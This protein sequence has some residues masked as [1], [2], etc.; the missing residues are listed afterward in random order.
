MRTL[1]FAIIIGFFV[2]CSGPDKT[3]T[4]SP[5]D[6]FIDSLLSEMTIE[7]KIG[8]MS[9]STGSWETTG[10]IIADSSTLDLVRT[11]RLGSFLNVFGAERTRKAQEIAVNGS[12]LGIPLIFGYDM[13]HGYA[14]T[15]PIPLA[16][17][18]SWDLELIK[19]SAAITALEASAAGLHWN[20][21]PMVD[22]ARDPRWGRIMEGAGEDPWWGSQVAIARVRGY[23]GNDL[24]S[25]STIAAT[26]KHFAGYGAA[27][28]GRDY[29]T[30][31]ISEH[32]LRDV[33]LVPFQ[34]AAKAGVAAFM[35]GFN[36][37]NGT[38][39]TANKF[40]VRQILKKEWDW[41]GLVVSDWAS[42]QELTDHG[43]AATDSEAAG[44]AL[45]AGCDMEMVSKT[46]DE[47]LID[48]VQQHPEYLPMID[49][50]TLRI[51]GVK[52]DLGLFEDPFRY[53]DLQREKQ[54]VRNNDHFKHAREIAKRSIVL[55]ENRNRTLPLD[56][57]LRKIAVIGPLAEDRE[58]ALGTW[59]AQGQQSDVTPLLQGIQLAVG[60]K[61]KVLYAA[62]SEI[63]STDKS[64]FNKARAL[65][66]QSDAIIAVVGEHAL[67]SG[68]ALS[69]SDIGLPG[70]QLDLLKMLKETGKPVIVVLMNGRP[71]AEPWMYENCDAV[72]ETW[73]LGVQ[74]GPAIA[75]VIFG[76]YNPA[77]K[78]PVTIPRSVGQIPIYYNHKNTGRAADPADRYTSK[79][80]DEAF[81]P[82]YPFG[83]GLSYTTFEY[84]ELT[85]DKP[86]F[87][88]GDSLSVSVV[89]TNSGSVA[90]EEVVQ[91][92]VRDLFGSVTRPVL[93]LKNFEKVL[94]NAGESHLVK[95]KI[96]AEDLSFWD[97]NM[98]FRSETGQFKVFVGSNSAT[99]LQQ[100]FEL[101]D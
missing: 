26:A 18:A 42:V 16:E 44:L 10:P 36:D 55:L 2:G 15:F 81:V 30:T 52:Y 34:A 71:I 51:L 39:A 74:S 56:P 33:Y 17:A 63:N 6:A 78:L 3:T 20:F 45:E 14:T 28:G 8:Q 100:E 41:K 85:L 77:G 70:V 61:T 49:D 40:L 23:Q 9:Q 43:F 80:I 24:K 92:Y 93:E 35:N 54:I 66:K 57:N 5:R 79:Y 59:S 1:V 46:Y 76:S 58:T 64:G 4:L 101:L 87:H 19:K 67:M 96:K 82:Q 83:Y 13:I 48:L 62:G 65:A 91:L 97:K 38:P 50:A 11:G 72:L 69:R 90:G 27:E 99:Q 94:L 37:L 84:G 95:F 86:A 32:T 73:L 98:A 89:L 31:E 47:Y 25:L 29:N 7:E 60:E 88:R 12:R 21:A 22:I 53:S 75:D 68:E